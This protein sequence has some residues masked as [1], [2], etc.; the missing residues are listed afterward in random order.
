MFLEKAYSG[1]SKSLKSNQVN[2]DNIGYGKSKKT[3]ADAIL[4][5]LFYLFQNFIMCSTKK[6]RG[7]F[8]TQSNIKDRVYEENKRPFKNDASG[9]EGEGYPKLVTRSD[10]VGRGY[11]QIVTLPQQKLSINF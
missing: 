6:L 11:M 3:L 8:R 4:Y 7:V 1:F 9:T 10:I 5:L 2:F